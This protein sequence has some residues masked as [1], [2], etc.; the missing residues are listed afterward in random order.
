MFDQK[1][2]KISIFEKNIAIKGYIKLDGQKKNY[3]I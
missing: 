3:K 2:I 1:N